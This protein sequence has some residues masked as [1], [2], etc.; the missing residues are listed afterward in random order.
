[1]RN[2]D[3][4]LKYKDNQGNPLHGCVMFNVK[5]GN[6]QAP[7]F[8][9]DGTALQNPILT[10]EYGRTQ[11]QVFVDTDVVAYF[12]K[13]IGTGRYQEETNIDVSDQT[14]WTLQYTAESIDDVTL[15]ITGDSAMC[16]NSIEELRALD[17]QTVP[18]IGNTK[19]ITLLGYNTSGDKSPINYYWNPTSQSGDNS[20]SII[21]SDDVLTGRWIMVQPTEVCDCRHFGIFPSNSQNNTPDSSSQIAVW[22]SYCNRSMVRPYF[23]GYG[24]YKY[25]KYSN[26][27]LGTDTIEVAPGVI[28]NDIGSNTITAEWVGDPTFRNHLT[29]LVCKKPKTSW[30]AQTLTGYEVVNIDNEATTFTLSYTGAE[31]NIN[32]T[33]NTLVFMF[34][35]CKVFI[36]KGFNTVSHFNNCQIFSSKM[37]SSGCYFYGCELDENMFYGSPFIHVDPYCT[38]PLEQFKNKQLMW[39]RICD[40]Q[41]KINYDWMNMLTTEAPWDAAVN[42]DRWLVNWKG[43]SASN[44]IV[45]DPDHPH[46]YWF[47]N[48]AGSIV[49][50]GKQANTY[51]FKNCEM[52]VT[53]ADG[54][55]G[56]S[57]VRFQDSTINFTRAGTILSV[58][59]CQDSNIMGPGSFDVMN[60]YLYRS[61]IGANIRCGYCDVKDCNI[62]STI[63]IYG[64]DQADPIQVDTGLGLIIP[65]YR[66]I[67]GNIV[68]NFIGGNIEIGTISEYTHYVSVDLVRGLCIKD[69]IG[70]SVEPVTVH[71]S[72]SSQYDNYN[73]YTYQGNTGTMEMKTNCNSI[74]YAGT[75]RFPAGVKSAM[76]IPFNNDGAMVWTLGNDESRDAYA[77]Y[78]RL[79]T[80]G[81]VNVRVPYRVQYSSQNSNAEM[82]HGASGVLS[83][84]QDRN[85]NFRDLIKLGSGQFDWG[86]R[87]GP[88]MDGLNS[89]TIDDPKEVNFYLIQQ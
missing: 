35:N 52:T 18:T 67:S 21:K 59:N 82:M 78:V 84:M 42:S 88:M 8:D 2:V 81:T 27:T 48:C 5:D 65:V 80:I 46:T 25:Y 1:M 57:V 62:S 24:D 68:G 37:I 53:F 19:T 33:I 74:I 40:Q 41:S 10:D 56:A 14:K 72:M 89:V 7:I 87:F 20:G 77:F 36:N 73:I 50:Q 15:H 70:L 3:L 75:N 51:V 17:P 29:N 30:G 61:A 39:K 28:F 23:A 31:I 76:T 64:I 69:N 45:E 60:A 43:I 71:R 83:L 66:I 38:A 54:Y 12:Y 26:L 47:E 55:N 63:N 86:V 32:S 44:T 11:H 22:I 34:E 85:P 16:V 13:Y 4:W 58:L 9:S 79:F 49:L 6:T